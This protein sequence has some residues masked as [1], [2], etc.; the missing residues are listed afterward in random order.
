M[1]GHKFSVNMLLDVAL[2]KTSRTNNVHIF[3]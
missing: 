3:G 1:N 2:I